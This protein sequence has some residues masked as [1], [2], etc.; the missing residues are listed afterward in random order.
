MVVERYYVGKMTLPTSNISYY[1]IQ[2]DDLFGVELVEELDMKSISV[3]EYFTEDRDEALAFT[4]M[5][6]KHEVTPITL[7]DIVDDYI[8]SRS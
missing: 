1:M 5:I 4:E 6:C 3:L 7:T 2:K 8:G